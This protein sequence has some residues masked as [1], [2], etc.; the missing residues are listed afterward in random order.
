[1]ASLKCSTNYSPEPGKQP[2]LK[3]ELLFLSILLMK[4]W[5]QRA[6]NT[7]GVRSSSRRICKDLALESKVLVLEKSRAHLG[8]Y[9]LFS[10]KADFSQL[11]QV[12]STF[13]KRQC[14]R[15]CPTSTKRRLP[16]G[17]GFYINLLTS[18]RVRMGS[19][20]RS[21]AAV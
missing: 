9:T 17:L 12:D 1:M 4:A 10:T 15:Q 6:H 21:V 3:D 2:H 5:A 11:T 20:T 13:I 16:C 14:P 7:S 18:S 19:G 8:P